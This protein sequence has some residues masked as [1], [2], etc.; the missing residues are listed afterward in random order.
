MKPTKN[1]FME[2][3][4]RTTEKPVLEKV[5]DK[6]M[7]IQEELDELA[8]QLALGKAEA[9][10]KFE[11]VKKEFKKK[12]TELKHS[13]TTTALN[14]MSDVVKTKFEE[15]ELQLALGKADTAEIF[16]AQSK[17]ILQ[18]LHNLENE[19]K[20]DLQQSN[21]L[22][23]FSHDMEN[24][25]LKMEILRLKFVLKK[26]EIKD[27]FKEKMKEARK[28]VD[29]FKISAQEKLREGKAQ[30]KDFKGEVQ[31]AYKHLRK[32]LESL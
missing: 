26:F 18:S 13:L 16:E 8:L 10:D 25:K 1:L 12:V 28:A 22:N 9:K 20:K 15:L 3:E 29:K 5:A 4:E 14:K 31:L 21:D 11:E 27:A 17:K 23:S 7:K 30:Y 6:L 24:F 19:I 32:A 2:P